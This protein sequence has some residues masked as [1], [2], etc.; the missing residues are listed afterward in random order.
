MHKDSFI[1]KLQAKI[2]KYCNSE[3]KEIDKIVFCVDVF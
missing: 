1:K 2:R 3:E